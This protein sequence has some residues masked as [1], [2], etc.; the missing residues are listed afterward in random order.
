MEHFFELPINYKDQ[1]LSLKARLVTFAYEYKFYIMVE[2]QELI[3]ER[4]DSGAFRA[5]LPS[6]PSVKEISQEL[7]KAIIA[8]LEHLQADKI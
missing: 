5:I 4:D 2:G 1:E 3:F 6:A 8:T 7:L